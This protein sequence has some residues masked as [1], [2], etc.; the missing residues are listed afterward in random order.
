MSMLRQAAWRR[1]VVGREDREKASLSRSVVGAPPG[2]GI[3]RRARVDRIDAFAVDDNLG[4]TVFA[5]RKLVRSIAMRRWAQRATLRRFPVYRQ[6]V[7]RDSQRLVCLHN[8][9]WVAASAEI[10]SASRLQGG[11]R[12]AAIL[13]LH[14]PRRQ[15]ASA[16]ARS[17]ADVEGK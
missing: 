8:R 17:L 2:F 14:A 15:S 11:A 7:D 5:L 13:S 9:E 1:R 3:E 4:W 12:R 6:V 16:H 10:C